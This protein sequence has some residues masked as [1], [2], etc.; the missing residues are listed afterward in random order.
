[1]TCELHWLPRILK[2]INWLINDRNLHRDISLKITESWNK[3]YTKKLPYPSIRLGYTGANVV[4]T[5]YIW[6]LCYKQCLTICKNFH[7]AFILMKMMFEIWKKGT[8]LCNLIH[9]KSSDTQCINTMVKCM[10]ISLSTRFHGEKY[11]WFRLLDMITINP[12]TVKCILP[13]YHS[14]ANPFIHPKVHTR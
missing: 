9:E 3:W 1:M 10:K 13:I 14:M 4:Y 6:S 12:Y 2:K 7:Y 5:N 8:W 11:Y